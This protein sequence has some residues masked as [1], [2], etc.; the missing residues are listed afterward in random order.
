MP[1]GIAARLAWRLQDTETSAFPAWNPEFLREG[2]AV[3]DTT[4]PDRLVYGLPPGGTEAEAVKALLDEAY[5][6]ALGE[7]APLVV[8]D[9][10]TAEL[11]KVAANAIFATKISSINTMAEI[12]EVADADVT[13]LRR[14][15]T[16]DGSDAAF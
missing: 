6:T 11:V 2:F 3:R 9:Y 12:A 4:S 16:T 1:V 8:A 13:L 7:G 15:D 5:A 10:R 14:S